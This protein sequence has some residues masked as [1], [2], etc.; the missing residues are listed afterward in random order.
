MLWRHSIYG[1]PS[2]IGRPSGGPSP[3]TRLSAMLD[4]TAAHFT[5]IKQCKYEYTVTCRVTTFRQRRTAY[6]TVVP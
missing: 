4:Q 2:I 5:A 6:T 3:S 1:S